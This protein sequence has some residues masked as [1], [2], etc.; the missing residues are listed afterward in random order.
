MSQ[1]LAL[2][3]RIGRSDLTPIH[4]QAVRPYMPICF[5]GYP[6]IIS[7]L[8]GTYIQYNPEV[9]AHCNSAN[10]VGRS[11]SRGNASAFARTTICFS[12]EM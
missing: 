10:G 11:A 6:V 2:T 8:W 1:E 4:M 9:R 5:S 12:C 7:M 3:I